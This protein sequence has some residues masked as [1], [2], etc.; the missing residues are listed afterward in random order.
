MKLK[1]IKP[2]SD[3][4]WKSIKNNFWK[5]KIFRTS[6]LS[7]KNKRLYLT[8]FSVFLIFGRY[9]GIERHWSFKD[10]NTYVTVSET[11]PKVISSANLLFFY[12]K[13]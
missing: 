9:F 4:S 3:P 1:N 5:I 7:L 10:Y 6:K 13:I 11:E 8:R 2:I 12:R